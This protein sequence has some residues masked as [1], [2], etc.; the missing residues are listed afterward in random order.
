MLN[1]AT[2]SAN[3]EVTFIDLV[4]NSGSSLVAETL[5][6]G[7]SPCFQVDNSKNDLTFIIIGEA[8]HSRRAL[9]LQ[10]IS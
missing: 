3:K 4:D 5:N 9:I 8:E 7:L 6:D 1:E 10:P 2:F